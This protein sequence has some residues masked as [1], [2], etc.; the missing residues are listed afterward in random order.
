[1]T[2]HVTKLATTADHNEWDSLPTHAAIIGAFTFG[3]MLTGLLG[4]NYDTFKLGHSYGRI[5]TAGFVI[6]LIAFAADE[7][8]DNELIHLTFLSMAC[9]LQ[10]AMTTKFSG[11]MIRT[12]HVTGSLTDI[13]LTI[14]RALRGRREQLW[15]LGILVPMTIS[16]FIGSLLGSVFLNLL[17]RSSVIVN[18]VLFG[19]TALL[20]SVYFSKYFKVKFWEA[21]FDTIEFAAIREGGKDRSGAAFQDAD[22]ED[23]VVYRPQSRNS[24]GDSNFRTES[25]DEYY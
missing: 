2:G 12:T 4:G 22:S 18:I 17:Q 6:L 21:V 9:G 15:K 3:S 19:A 1:M 10:N 13:G 7:A 24:T 14:G 20:Y 25:M 5:F 23:V 16:F 8:L 11:S